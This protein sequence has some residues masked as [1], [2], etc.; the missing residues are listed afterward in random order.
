MLTRF[1]VV[2]PARD[3]VD[4][5]PSCLTALQSAAAEVGPAAVE[6]VVVAD[7]CTDGTAGAARAYGAQV[8]E[9]DAGRVGAAR[10]AGMAHALRDGTDGLWLATTDADSRVPGGWLAAQR[11][12]AEAG[13]E[14]VVGTV[15]VDDW[16]AWPAGVAER[17]DAGYRA[18]FAADGHRHV[19]GANL[20][21]AATAYEKVGG[22]AD[23]ALDEDRDLVDRLIAAGARVVRDPELPVVTS[24]RRTARAPAGFA[25]FLAGLIAPPAVP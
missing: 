24:A 17:H 2:V 9:I 13:I 4:L 7:S 6:I 25:G 14:L 19:H 23:L 20:G 1:A 22:F 21:C 12:H 8:I 16:A 5:L 10:A 18:E 3:E 11:A 15:T